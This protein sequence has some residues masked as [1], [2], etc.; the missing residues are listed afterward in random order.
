MAIQPPP[1]PVET[2]LPPPVKK[3]RSCWGCGC[4]GCLLVV[5]LVALLVGGGA[6]WILIVQAQAAVTSP[7]ALLLIAAPVDV[8][9]NDSGYK[10]GIPGQQLT[11]GNSVRTGHAGHAAIQF[12][13]GS[14][15][16]MAPDT[17]VTVTAAQLTHDGK[18]QSASLVQKVG[19]T[20]SS[21]QHLSNGAPFQVGG[22]SVSASVRGTEFEV[23]V[24]TNGTNVIKVFDGSVTVSG[25]TTTT[26]TAGQQIDADANGK[27]SI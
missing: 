11:A 21:V 3:G 14:N 12:P 22:H 13:D 19:R 23:L 25:T 9:T 24:R 2:Q 10:S 1:A 6:Y 4:G 7:A 5:V 20:F 15:T 17:T 8:G 18:L 27:L 26:L 16:R